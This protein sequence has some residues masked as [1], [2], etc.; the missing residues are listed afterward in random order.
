MAGLRDSSRETDYIARMGGDEFVLVPPSPSLKNV[1]G[2][3]NVL[4]TMALDAGIALCGERPA[5]HQYRHGLDAE[6]L[7]ADRRIYRRSGYPLPALRALA[8]VTLCL[9]GD[10]V[11]PARRR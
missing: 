2:K 7:L 1:A 3:M 6:S 5:P 10:T 9:F 4:E 11:S 8:L